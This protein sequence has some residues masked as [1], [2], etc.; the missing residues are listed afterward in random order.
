[1]AKNGNEIKRKDVGAVKKDAASDKK[2]TKMKKIFIVT[3]STFVLFIGCV[4]DS[5][6]NTESLPVTGHTISLLFSAVVTKLSNV[7]CN[8]LLELLAA[9]ACFLT[10]PKN[11]CETS[12]QIVYQTALHL[13]VQLKIGFYGKNLHV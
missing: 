2:D 3:I 1:M 6:V 7:K 4:D 5:S 8:L 12:C 10:H 13:T 11:L 9:Y